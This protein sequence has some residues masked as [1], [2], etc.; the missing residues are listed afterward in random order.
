MGDCALI[1]LDWGTTNL[2]AFLFSDSGEVLETRSSAQG[3]A[4]ISRH[5]GANRDKRA[6]GFSEAFAELCGD[7]ASAQ[8]ELPVI[9]T[10]MIGS[11]IGLAETHYECTP[12][13]LSDHGF[14]L[15]KTRLGMV[16]AHIVPGVCTA[17]P[18]PSIMRGE[19]TTLV[20]LLKQTSTPSSM[21]ILPGTH[22]K[23]VLVEDGVITQ[24]VTM[25]TG[26]LYDLLTTESTL[27]T[28]AMGSETCWESFDVGVSTAIANSTTLGLDGT[29][30]VTRTQ[31][32]LS[33]GEVSSPRDFLSGLLIGSEVERLKATIPSDFAGETILSAP[34]TLQERYLRV[35]SRSGIAVK[36]STG[37]ETSEG[38]Y[39][40]AVKHGLLGE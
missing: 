28:P 34:N 12:I 25:M 20:G 17:A 3:A 5:Y 9:A 15:V 33:N 35:L 40:L 4:K 36:L 14:D 32:V 37:A 7:W 29:L 26:E 22:S 19:E 39:E 38:L 6:N 30:F 31:A 13:D 18:V 8:G 10:G 21:H 23:C 24:F 16:E 27:R 1:G 11:D 2:R